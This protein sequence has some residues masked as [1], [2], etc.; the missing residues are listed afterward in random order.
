[1][2]RS[3][4]CPDCDGPAEAFGE[5][6]QNCF[7]EGS[8]CGECGL[9]EC[10]WEDLDQCRGDELQAEQDLVWAELAFVAESARWRRILAQCEEA[11]FY[12]RMGYERALREHGLV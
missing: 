10:L 7:G 3:S 9:A 1:M 2:S 4:V 12:E 8:V 6:C 5:E 11:R